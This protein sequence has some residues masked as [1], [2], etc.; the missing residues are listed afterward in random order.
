MANSSA[1]LTWPAGPSPTALHSISR[2]FKEENFADRLP[3]ES[4]Y[5]T[6]ELYPWEKTWKRHYFIEGTH[7]MENFNT[8][9]FHLVGKSDMYRKTNLFQTSKNDK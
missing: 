1:F 9:D 7:I 8:P 2:M 4:D 6:K 3:R 5:S